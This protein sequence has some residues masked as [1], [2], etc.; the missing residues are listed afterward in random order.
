[1]TGIPKR[2]PEPAAA[3]GPA[4]VHPLDVPGAR[5]AYLAATLLALLS[6][7]VLLVAGMF[8]LWSVSDNPVTPVL[9]P[10]WT[11]ILASLAE[12]RYRADAWAHIPR[13]N[14]DSARND[15]AVVAVAA[16]GIPPVCLA[17]AAWAFLLATETH[18]AAAA[19]AHWGAGAAAALAVVL[20][21][22]MAWD[23]TAS[24]AYR[25]SRCPQTLTTAADTGT[26]LILAAVF[27]VL[28]GK[29]PLEIPALAL[30]GG[31]VLAVSAVWGIF[32][33]VPGRIPCLPSRFLLR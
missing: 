10:A 21:A 6:S 30:G 4:L 3:A 1:M 29:A 2:G 9:A 28:A 5:R 15:P 31:V 22:T 24:A 18:P 14:Q 20:L 23:R 19:A 16:A 12:R 13:R 26:L 8:L 11:L 17:A 25:I 7:P 32:Q 27:G 33:L